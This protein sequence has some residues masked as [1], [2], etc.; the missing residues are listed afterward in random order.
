VAVKPTPAMPPIVIEGDTRLRVDDANISVAGGGG[1]V[2][3]AGG[4]VAVTNPAL[5]MDNSVPGASIIELSGRVAAPVRA[6][7]ALVE[8]QQPGALSGLDLPI[9]LHGLTGALD[10]D[11]VATIALGDEE[12]GRPL[13]VDYVVNGNAVDFASADPI[14]G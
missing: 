5:V 8:E 6:I 13:K 3:S 4:V 11:L 1:T 2:D 14:E 10:M 12:T 9:D 7:L